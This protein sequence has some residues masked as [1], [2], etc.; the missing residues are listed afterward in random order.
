MTS[1]NIYEAPRTNCVCIHLSNSNYVNEGRGNRSEILENFPCF[2]AK[3]TFE[4]LIGEFFYFAVN[5]RFLLLLLLLFF[6]F[7]YQSIFVDGS[8]AM[9]RGNARGYAV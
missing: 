2:R 9:H 1:L 5:C 8:L 4:T 7:D 3:R 6:F